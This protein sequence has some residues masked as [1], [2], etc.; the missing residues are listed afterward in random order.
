VLIKIHAMKIKE[1]FEIFP[2]H[3][4]RGLPALSFLFSLRSE[5]YF[6]S[7]YFRVSQ[8]VLIIPYSGTSPLPFLN[9]SSV[10]LT[11]LLKK[12]QVIIWINYGSRLK[13]PTDF[14]IH[15]FRKNFWRPVLMTEAQM[16]EP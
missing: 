16:E 5:S 7:Q 14:W 11:L 9:Y 6:L 13:K 1:A 8:P 10:C 4:H 12:V 15:P 3:R 2:Q